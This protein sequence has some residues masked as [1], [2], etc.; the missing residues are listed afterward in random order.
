M[1]LITLLALSIISINTFAWYPGE[2]PEK[3]REINNQLQMQEMQNRLQELEDNQQTQ[4]LLST[5]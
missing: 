3:D 2:N 5:Q 4:E 1:K